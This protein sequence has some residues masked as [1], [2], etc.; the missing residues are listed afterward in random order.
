M[1]PQTVIGI[2]GLVL[3]IVVAATL[4]WYKLSIDEPHALAL[5][6]SM[7]VF[8][9]ILVFAAL[10]PQT[11]SNNDLGAEYVD[12]FSPFMLALFPVA[13][14]LKLPGERDVIRK[15]KSGTQQQIIIAQVVGLI[16]I[17]LL[18]IIFLFQYAYSSGLAGNTG[19]EGGFYF[20]GAV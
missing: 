3:G 11:L 10:L 20:L 1:D 4:Y 2:T 13:I 14:A 7:M 15:L 9:V 16:S 6:L 19:M 12:A 17:Q 5:H 8:G 18:Y